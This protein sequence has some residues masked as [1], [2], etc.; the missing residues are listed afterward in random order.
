METFQGVPNERTLEAEYINRNL[1]A[2]RAAYGLDNVEVTSY[3]AKTTATSDALKND[4]QTAAQIRI[5]DPNLVSASFRQLEQYRQYYNFVN[6]LD[7]DRY[8]I[9]GKTQDTVLAVR[10]LNQSGL[11]SSQS[12]YNNVIATNLIGLRDS[13]SN[14]SL[15][16]VPLVGSN[17][18]FRTPVLFPPPNK[19]EPYCSA[20][21]PP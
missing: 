6:H 4:A 10:E 1:A 17:V 11:G 7:V 19:S 8:T 21:K 13:P 15:N 16:V 5:I 3:A 2:T 12:W 14:R 18:S 20:P 9:N